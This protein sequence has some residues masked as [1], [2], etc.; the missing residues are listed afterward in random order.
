[1]A[2]GTSRYGVNEAWVTAIA[3]GGP[4]TQDAA[5]I[6]ATSSIDGTKKYVMKL[7]D[8]AEHIAIRLGYDTATTGI[9]TQC[10]VKVFGRKNRDF[11]SSA[12]VDAWA[13][14]PNRNGDISVTLTGVPSTDAD[15]TLSYTLVDEF[16]HVFNVRNCNE[17][18]VGV[19]TAF[20]PTNGSSAVSIVEM[21]LVEVE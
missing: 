1:M 16:D 3:A 15:D 13:V 12:S 2:L 10:V 21:K 11:A 14:L 6:T 17:V 8:G 18:V 7:P 9:T 4:A 20:S 19:E 5:T